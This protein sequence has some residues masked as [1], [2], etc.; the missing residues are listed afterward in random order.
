VSIFNCCRWPG[1]TDRPIDNYCRDHW[2]RL[3]L[4]LRLL[5]QNA[6]SSDWRTYAKVTLRINRWIYKEFP[7]FTKVARRLAVKTMLK[8]DHWSYSSYSLHKKCPAAFKYRYILKYVEPPFAA[9]VRGTA[10]HSL[11]EQ[12]LKGGIK[13]M[14]RQLRKLEREIK[15]LKRAEPRCEKYWG[16]NED[17][18]KHKGKGAWCVAKSDAFVKPTHSWNLLYVGD[19]KTGKIYPEHIDQASL[20]ATIGY[21]L[22]PR[23]DGV[24]AEMLYI[25]QGKVEGYE[26]TVPQL[27]YQVKLW[28]ERGRELMSATKFPATPSVW[29]CGLCG[30][31]SDKKLKNGRNGPCNEW[32]AIRGLR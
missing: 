6:A 29:N 31:R 21:V 11:A 2:N 23:V 24:L 26:Y 18:E 28:H 9:M 27:R 1:C 15:G 17:F 19:W 20:Y 14:P 12:Y 22:H 4:K 30:F 8:L 5:E 7:L 16:V 10:I 25:D 13:G 3:P 32:R